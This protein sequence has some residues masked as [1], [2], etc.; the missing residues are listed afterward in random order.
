[1]AIPPSPPE[2]TWRT[3]CC[4]R[5]LCWSATS[6]GVRNLRDQLSISMQW[7]QVSAHAAGVARDGSAALPRHLRGARRPLSA[8]ALP[9]QAELT[10]SNGFVSPSSA[11]SCW[12]TRAGRPPAMAHGTRPTG[13]P[14]GSGPSA[15]SCTMA[16]WTSSAPT[17][18]SS[19]TACEATGLGCEA[20]QRPAQPGAHLRLLPGQPGHPPG[21]H[22]ATATPST[23]SAATC[24]CRCPTARWTKR[25][26][27]NGC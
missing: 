6:V 5:Q 9:A 20:L 23:S 8:R 14:D 15:R 16:R 21:E 27:W 12:P 2:V 1:M 22:A 10:P 19:T 18:N 3:A 24:Y 13:H 7:S 4:Q 11:I 17:S 25:S 26:G